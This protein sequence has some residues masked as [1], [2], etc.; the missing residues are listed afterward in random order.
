MSH[1]HLRYMYLKYRARDADTNANLDNFWFKGHTDFGSL[2]LPFRQN[3]AALQVRGQ[4]G[5]RKWV[6]PHDGSIPVNVADALQFLTNGFPKGNIHRVMAPPPDHAGIDRLGVL[7]FVRPE[8]SLELKPVDSP[9]LW[10]LGYNPDENSQ[11]AEGITTGEWVHACV[12]AGVNRFE[13][14]RGEV[15]EQEILNGVKTTCF[16]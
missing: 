9:V 16:D 11:L 10:R 6:K 1:C 8:D 2:T 3:V 14:A 4:D 13:K 12:K 5:G 15:S 7:C